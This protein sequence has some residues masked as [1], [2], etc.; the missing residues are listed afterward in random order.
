MKPLALTYSSEHFFTV[1]KPAGWLS[2]PSRFREEDA[3]PVLG[4]AL[5][6]QL[7]QQIFPVH[8]LDLEVS[9]VMLW[10][11][12]AAA[13][14]AANRWFENSLVQKTY[15]AFAPSSD[16]Q[17][18][19]SEATWECKLLR[20]KKRAYENANGK[21]SKT[22]AIRQARFDRMDQWLL[23]PK[24]GRSHQ[25]RYEMY[26]HQIP[27]VGDTLYGSTMPWSEEGIALRATVLD[28]TGVPERLMWGL[29]EELRSARGILPI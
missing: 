26:R 18:L 21:P 16:F 20:G 9:G 10:A 8:R 27:I 11:L 29:P 4:L 5:Q 2:V 12:N 19:L 25:L 1:D 13:H 7:G 6:E 24:T 15:E 23:L 17:P 28:F 3:R 14:R 22:V